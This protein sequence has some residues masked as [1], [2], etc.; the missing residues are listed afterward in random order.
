M[1]RNTALQELRLNGNRLTTL[2]L[3][4]KANYRLRLLDLGN[5]LIQS[6]ACVLFVVASWLMIVA[7]DLKALLSL[8][9]LKNLTLR[10]N[11]V[12][13]NDPSGA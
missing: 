13:D 10:G 6:K 7:S 4:L 5:N 11:P 3:D 9:R 1:S 8:K 12:L 2:P